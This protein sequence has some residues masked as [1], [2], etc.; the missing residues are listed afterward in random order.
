MLS[1]GDSLGSKNSTADTDEAAIDDADVSN[2]FRDVSAKDFDEWIDV[3]SASQMRESGDLCSLIS[4][5]ICNQGNNSR[6]RIIVI[7][8]F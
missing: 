4:G 2:D 5:S 7:L 3:V 1:E 8:E 6:N